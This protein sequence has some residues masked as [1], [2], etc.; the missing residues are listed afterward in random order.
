MGEHSTIVRRLPIEVSV[1]VNRVI[2]ARSSLLAVRITR[3]IPIRRLYMI[4][5]C[6]FCRRGASE[7]WIFSTY[8]LCL[9]VPTAIVPLQE[10]PSY[11]HTLI[12]SLVVHKAESGP[13]V[14]SG[15]HAIVDSSFTINRPE[16]G[17]HQGDLGHAHSHSTTG[18][19]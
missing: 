3:P 9:L 12:T 18:L 6:A 7:R 10:T 19:G 14:S 16:A 2:R 1:P 8:Q 5:H 13:P 4:I 15:S 17:Q 11:I